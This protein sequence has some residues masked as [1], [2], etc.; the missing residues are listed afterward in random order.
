MSTKPWLRLTVIAAA[1]A[2]LALPLPGIAN[3]EPGGQAPKP[4]D[5]QAEIGAKPDLDN[6]R[7][8]VAPPASL[9]RSTSTATIRW[10]TLGTP[11]VITDSAPL[12]EGLGSDPEQAARAYLKANENL[13]GLSG[14]AVD[15]LEKVAVNPIG[16]GHAVLLRQRFGGLPRAW[17]GRSRSA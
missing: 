17:T 2:A 3:S 13:F 8:S 7:G 15:G 1:T 11:A 6:R 10:N 5:F 12:A 14:E 16:E 4:H 9:S